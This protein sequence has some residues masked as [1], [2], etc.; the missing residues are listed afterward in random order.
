VPRG[1]AA[2]EVR[3][4]RLVE[5]R[6]AQLV[7]ADEPVEPLMRDLVADRVRVLEVFEV[8]SKS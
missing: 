7:V 1:H 3:R 5:P 2:R 8:M 4:E 6:L